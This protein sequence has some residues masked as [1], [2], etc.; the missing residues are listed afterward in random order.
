[1]C[2][3]H[4]VACALHVGELGKHVGNLQK[5]EPEQ[6]DTSFEGLVVVQNRFE[7]E[8][9]DPCLDD[10]LRIVGLGARIGRGFFCGAEKAK[11]LVAF[12]RRVRRL[13]RVERA[14]YGVNGLFVVECTS[15]LVEARC[16]EDPATVKLF[17]LVLAEAETLSKLTSRE[18]SGLEKATLLH[19]IEIRRS[20]TFPFWRIR[21]RRVGEN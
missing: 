19:Q 17:E 14:T 1:M 13:F 18:F 10:H 20:S 2:F 8:V 7:R 5:I 3:R 4:E 16:F 11:D 9:V 21:Q 6:R 12:F 15:M